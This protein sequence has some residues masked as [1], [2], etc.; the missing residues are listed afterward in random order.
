M[1]RFLLLCAL[2][3]ACAHAENVSLDRV[4]ALAKTYFRDSAEVPMAVTVTSVATDARGRV[5]HRRVSQATMVFHGYSQ[6]AG[7][8]S[9]RATSGI[10]SAGGMRDS[11]SGDVAAF[12]AAM[13][14]VPAEG[15]TRE[16]VL[17]E[18]GEQGHPFIVSVA[19]KDCPPMQLVKRWMFPSK[20]CGSSEFALS[21]AP[22]GGLAFQRFTFASDGAPGPGKVA[23]FGDVQVTGFRSA[24]DFQEGFLPGDPKPFLWP[25]QTVVSIRTDKGT[26]EVKNEYRA[27]KK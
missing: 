20:P 22:G 15:T 7:K 10:F 2:P 5:K 16:F 8:F 12:F 6:K 23:Y 26:I 4:T 18:P 11:M 1:R 27:L 13:F 19:D 14:L 17:R 25:R 21:S 24:V 3:L 9:L